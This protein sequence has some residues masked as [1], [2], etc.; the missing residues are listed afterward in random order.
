MTCINIYCKSIV[1][2][3]VYTL[4]NPKWQVGTTCVVNSDNGRHLDLRPVF[5][6]QS[7]DII[8]SVQ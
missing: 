8:T 2:T 6:Y 4:R 1:Y 5:I 3:D 7:Q